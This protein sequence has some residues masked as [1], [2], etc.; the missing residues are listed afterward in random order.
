MEFKIGIN[1]NRCLE[2][3]AAIV[4]YKNYIL[5]TFLHPA[6]PKP[7]EYNIKFSISHNPVTLLILPHSQL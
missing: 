6:L 1:A 3:L 7:Y 4:T 5:I 2:H